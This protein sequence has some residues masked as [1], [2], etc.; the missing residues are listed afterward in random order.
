MFYSL[1]RNCCL[2]I[3]H[4]FNSKYAR[5]T[6]NRFKA[7]CGVSCQCER[8]IKPMQL[9]LNRFVRFV[10]VKRDSSRSSVCQCN[11]HLLCVCGYFGSCKFLVHE[12]TFRADKLSGKICW[13]IRSKG[14]TYG[15]H[16]GMHTCA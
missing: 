9:R 7:Y 4:K 10:S 3:H 11:I 16:G 15:A 2:S 13:K 1:P 12:H 8:D 6:K 14:N 5:N